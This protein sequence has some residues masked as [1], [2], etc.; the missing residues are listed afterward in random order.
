MVSF[1]VYIENGILYVL[2]RI[3][4]I[5]DSNENIQHTF[6]LKEIER[7]PCYPY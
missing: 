7:Y 3:A 5:G 2:I 4:L 1:C 6:M